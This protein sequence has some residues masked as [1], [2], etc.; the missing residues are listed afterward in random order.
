[1]ALAG[2]VA[3]SSCK[4]DT[5]LSSKDGLTSIPANAT[6]VFAINV[7]SLMEKADYENIKDL[8]FFKEAMKDAADE[9]PR[10][11]EIMQNPDEAG[12][13][14]NQKAY[15]AIEVDEEDPQNVFSAMVLSLS[16]ADLF[17][18]NI[19]SGDNDMEINN[20]EGFKYAQEDRQSILAWNDQ[21]AVIGNATSYTDLQEAVSAYFN[22]KP[23]ESVA[24]NKDLQKAFGE[25]HDVAMWFNSNP[26]ADNPAAQMALG[27]AEIDSEAL[28]DNYIHGYLDFEMGEMIGH[29]KMYLQKDLTKDFSKFFN[30]EVT[31]DFTAYVPK[32]D[33]LFAFTTALDIKGIDE[34]LSARPQSKGFIDYSLDKYDLSFTDFAETFGGDIFVVAQNTGGD[35]PGGLIATNITDN[36][37]LTKFLDLAVEFEVLIPDGNDVY[38]IDPGAGGQYR[39]NDFDVAFE[40]GMMRLIVEKDMVFI[41]GDPGTLAVVQN[42]GYPAG[43][44]AEGEIPALLGKHVFGGYMALA[45]LER[46]DESIQDFAFEDMKIMVDREESN[47][48]LQMEDKSENALKQLIELGNESYLRERDNWDTSDS[49]QEL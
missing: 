36:E 40:D 44:R 11:A 10:V 16:D 8:D 27:F 2:L 7:P 26:F 21:M 23:E 20:G 19:K 45:A 1:M 18:S 35:K 22:T 43:E 14:L 24:G 12:V 3:L 17:E 15:M 6:T 25:E 37:L 30:D 33:L 39:D 48:H 49:S 29:S 42:G 9:N 47:F 5:P 46:L 13:D 28:K 38:K 32:D 4:K 31:T 41:T 34:V